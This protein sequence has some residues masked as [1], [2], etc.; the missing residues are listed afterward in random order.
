MLRH[1]FSDE[2]PRDDRPVWV[3]EILAK[4]AIIIEKQERM[5]MVDL[6][7]LKTMADRLQ[8]SDTAILAV[9]Q[10]VKDQNTA[11]A[12]Q[13]AAI[14][15]GDPTSQAAVDAIAKELSDS[16]DGIDAAVTA[17]T[18][19]PNLAPSPAATPATAPAT[20]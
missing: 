10:S 14:T 4:M 6:T 16:A 15:T 19:V 17:N 5:I 3:L 11:L 9:L 7:Q 13:L 12:A 20:A 8:A 18:A 2:T 1:D